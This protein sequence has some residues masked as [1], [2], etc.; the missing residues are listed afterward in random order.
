VAWPGI[1]PADLV[2]LDRVVCCYGDVDALVERA[3]S[4]TRQATRDRD[5]A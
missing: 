4:L 5:P 3:V 2:A 1:E